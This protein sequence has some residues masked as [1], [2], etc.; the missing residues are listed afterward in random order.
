MNRNNT[1][2]S[3]DDSAIV[4]AQGNVI[5][6]ALDFLNGELGK[7]FTLSERLSGKSDA[8]AVESLDGEQAVL[9]VSNDGSCDRVE[10]TV[11][12]VE[13]LRASGYATPRPLY[14]GLL[15]GGGC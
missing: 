10:Q 14:Y 4:G 6:R 5:R 9:K 1:G 13:H 8:W 12:L 15:P 2:L 3:D 7:Q 11:R